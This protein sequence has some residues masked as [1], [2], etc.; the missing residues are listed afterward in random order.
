MGSLKLVGRL[1]GQRRPAVNEIP[2]AR[3]TSRD[4]PEAWEG[5]E[6]HC[7]RVLYSVAIA[8]QRE[9]HFVSLA[10]GDWATTREL[11]TPLFATLGKGE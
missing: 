10:G 3:V 9:V 5:W 4:P 6:I 11:A 2:L 1:W 8:P 7:A